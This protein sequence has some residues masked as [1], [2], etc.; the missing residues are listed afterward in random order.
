M[1][2]I[3]EHFLPEVAEEA[4][5]YRARPKTP[6]RQNPDDFFHK[7]RIAA[8]IFIFL[9][10]SLSVYLFWDMFA[11][12]ISSLGTAFSRTKD[13]KAESVYQ[14][15]YNKGYEAGEK[16]HHV[17][18]RAFI[19]IGDLRET[20]ELEV[21]AVSEVSYQ[22]QKPEENTGIQGLLEGFENMF[23]PGFTVWLEVPG[24]GV[25][26]VDLQAGEFIIDPVRQLVLIRLP[27]PE[28]AH[29]TVEYDNVNELYFDQEGLFSGTAKSGVDAAE[30]LL[31]DAHSNMM[32]SV[33]NNQDF[34]QRARDAAENMLTTLVKQLNPHLPDLQV[35]VE[36]LN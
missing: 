19:S 15:F 4:S 18:N 23:K 32:Q 26:T 25:F 9:S 30:T 6:P 14:N 3:A 5:E 2:S 33:A 21:L 29:F 36:F 24:S 13:E 27:S 11:A 17:S 34:H 28:L 22:E 16:A 20:Q 1:K 8:I 12:G 31:K 35:E 10:L 7:F